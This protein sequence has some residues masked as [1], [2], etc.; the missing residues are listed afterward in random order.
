MNSKINITTSVLWSIYYSDD[1]FTNVYIR[2]RR[3]TCR[4][5]HAISEKMS[6]NS[7]YYIVDFLTELSEFYPPPLRPLSTPPLLSIPPLSI[8]PL[9]TP[10]SLHPPSLH[11]PS[12]HPPSLHP[13]YA[14]PLSTPLSTLYI[15]A[16][17]IRFL[18]RFNICIELQLQCTKIKY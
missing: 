1:F 6:P 13:L 2:C 7:T 10:P 18:T 14:L 15:Y 17:R 4:Y 12:L 3:H 8:P 11:P 16:L 5:Q 9:S